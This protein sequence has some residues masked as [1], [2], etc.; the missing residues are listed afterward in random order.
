MGVP[1]V[2]RLGPG[3]PYGGP[4]DGR[5]GLRQGAAG[6]DAAGAVPAPQRA[7]PG[8]RVEL[9]GRQPPGARLGRAVRLPHRAGAPGPG[10]PAVPAQR[11][12][13]TAGQL[14]LVDQPQGPHGAQRLRGGLP[15]PGQHR[16]LRPLRP[17]AHRGHA[18][19]GGRDGLDG[20]LRPE[21]AGD[22]PGAGGGRPPVRGHGAQV[23]RALPVDRG[24]DGPYRGPAGRAVGRGGRLLLRRPAP[25]GRAGAAPQGALDGGAAPDVRHDGGGR[26]HYSSASRSCW[27]ALSA[28]CAFTP[29]CRRTSPPCTFPAWRGGA[30][31]GP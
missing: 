23:L 29:S 8:L 12:P 26:R 9:R 16:G 20:H 13:Q 11:L 30:S 25:P 7:D 2:R 1:L 15:G 18:G 24:R 10:R 31:W 17:P 22:G 21:H 19:A 28:S 5:S 14:H 3:V 27:S 6:A 4:G